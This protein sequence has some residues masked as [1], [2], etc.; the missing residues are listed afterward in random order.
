MTR[1]ILK[2][3]NAPA[4]VLLTAIGIALQ[5]SLFASSF[6][7]YL[8]PDIVLL[9]VIWVGLRRGFAEGGIITLVI[10]DIAEVHSAAPQGFFLILYMAIYLGVRGAYKLLVIPNLTSYVYLTLVASLSF[11]I[12][13]AGLLKLLGAASLPWGHLLFWMGPAAAIEAAAGIWIY[14]WL[15]QFDMKTFKHARSEHHSEHG[16]DPEL[17]LEEAEGF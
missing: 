12:L 8:Q 4:L 14:R 17:Q 13:S 16:L 10:A 5:T 7:Q 3:L 11:K 6:L 2:A 1:L 9:V 15:E